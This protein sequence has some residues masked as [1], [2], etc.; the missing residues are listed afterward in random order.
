LANIPDDPNAV[1]DA[2]IANEMEGRKIL[3]RGQEAASTPLAK[4]TF[5][6]LANEETHHIE[7]IEEFSQSLKGVKTWDPESMK[8]I[9]M[10]EVG[11]AIKGIFERF[12]T[13][14]EAVATADDERLEI[15]KVAMDMERRG[16]DFY[17]SAAAKSE[18]PQAKGF[19][20]FLAHE[21]QRHY[22]MIQDTHDFLAQPDALLAMEE[23]WMQT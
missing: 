18:D 14:F 2:A 3:L 23:R 21:E 16:F 7:L 6:F 22:Q 1:L 10:S 13:Q 4:A 19:Y 20:T 5:Q 12:A 15:Y 8:E 11:V 17:S 9:S